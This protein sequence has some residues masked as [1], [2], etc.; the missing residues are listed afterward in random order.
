MIDGKWREVIYN[1][2]IFGCKLVI[3]KSFDNF[4][5]LLSI[6]LEWCD[7]RGD[8]VEPALRGGLKGWTTGLKDGIDF[9]LGNRS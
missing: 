6:G 2:A 7:N 5:E 4:I 8:I 9:P 1:D 3:Y